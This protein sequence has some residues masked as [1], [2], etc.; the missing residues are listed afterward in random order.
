MPAAE[1]PGARRDERD[2]PDE[3]DRH[4]ERGRDRHGE[5]GRDRRGEWEPVGTVGEEFLRLAEA[6]GSR[7]GAVAGPLAGEATRLLDSVTDTVRQ[8]HPEVARHLTAAGGEL[9]A[10]WR[11]VLADARRPPAASPADDGRDGRTPP[12]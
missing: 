10:A 12:D 6:A 2:G 5:R 9:L 4:G 3:R 11:A 1:D 7:L 8:R